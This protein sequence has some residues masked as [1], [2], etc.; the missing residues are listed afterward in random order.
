MRFTKGIVATAAAAGLAISMASPALASN[1]VR[2]VV[3]PLNWNVSGDWEM[4]N[5][6]WKKFPFEVQAGGGPQQIF[7]I[8]HEQGRTWFGFQAD[9][10]SDAESL[11]ADAQGWIENPT[12]GEMKKWSENKTLGEIPIE[13]SIAK[14]DDPATGESFY[15]F[16]LFP[17]REAA[18]APPA[19]LALQNLHQVQDEGV[20]PEDCTVSQTLEPG[21]TLTTGGAN[22]TVCVTVSDGDGS[23][24]APIKVDTGDGNDVVLIDGNT[25]APVVVDAGRGNDVVVTDTDAEVDVRGG[26]GHD[27]A[28]IDKGDTF[29]GGNGTDKAVSVAMTDE[30]YTKWMVE[31]CTFG[32]YGDC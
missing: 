5:W 21:D 22:D 9:F 11:K 2:V 3:D 15:E 13:T 24:D 23:S 32:P 16:K 8:D 30:E 6:G 27:A 1:E 29:D 14:F 12:L 19:D 26:E 4:K 18:T 20:A 31:N 10:N 7:T 28:V 25:D 17:T